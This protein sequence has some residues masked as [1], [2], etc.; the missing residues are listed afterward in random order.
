MISILKYMVRVEIN[1][2]NDLMCLYKCDNIFPEAFLKPVFISLTSV[3]S[4]LRPAC[5][6]SSPSH[7]SEIVGAKV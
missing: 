2:S 1:H 7:L 6:I 5:F 3:G 4:D